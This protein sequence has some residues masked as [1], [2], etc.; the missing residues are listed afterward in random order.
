MYTRHWLR[1]IVALA[2]AVVLFAPVLLSLRYQAGMWLLMAFAVSAIASAALVELAARD[3][4]DA[5]PA[6]PTR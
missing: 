1:W 2:S 5:R 6:T 4:R 3:P